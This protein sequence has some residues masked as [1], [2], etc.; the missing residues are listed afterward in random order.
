MRLTLEAIA[1][2]DGPGAALPAVSA[3]ASTEAPG[4]AAVETEGA[5]TL[6]SLVAGGR[7]AAES[8]RVLIDGV[9]DAA[10][11]RRSVALVDTPTVA[12]PFADLSVLTVVR[13]DLVLAGQHGNRDN[14]RLFLK[15]TGL[16]EHEDTRM[17]ALPTRARTRLLTELAVLR[18]GVEGVVLTS[19]ERHG[20]GVD[21]WWDVV[22]DLSARGFC[23]L[24][25]TGVAAATTL[26]SLVSAREGASA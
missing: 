20:G 2:G 17:R 24:V 10:K 5:P 7:M 22:E 11:I 14:A 25:V 18:E 13:E 8:G 23:V 1:I 4:V 12:E 16:E 3:E 26:T 9:D 6:A 15:A 19:P 21:D